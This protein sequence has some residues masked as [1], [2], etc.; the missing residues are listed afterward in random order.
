M[1]KGNG[2][3]VQFD[4]AAAAQAIADQISAAQKRRETLSAQVDTLNSEIETIDTFIS[5]H[6][7]KPARKARKGGNGGKGSRGPRDPMGA[8]GRVLQALS[9]ADGGLNAE[10]TA[11]AMV[12]AGY[13]ESESLVGA[14]RVQFGKLEEAGEVTKVERGIYKIN[15]AGRKALATIEAEIKGD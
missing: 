11:A 9:K 8:R 10:D 1:A 3:T 2:S 13:P 6:S 7:G 12:K 14:V 15:S 5:T 4:T